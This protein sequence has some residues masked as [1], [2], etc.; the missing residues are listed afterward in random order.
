MPAGDHLAGRFSSVYRDYLSGAERTFFAPGAEKMVW[1]KVVQTTDPS[2]QRTWFSLFRSIAITETGLMNLGKTWES[3]LLPGGLKLNEDELCMPAL[4]LAMN[5]HSDTDEIIT[6][7]RERIT[8]NDHLMRFDFVVPSVSPD[9]AVRDA[10]FDS[11]RDPVNREHEP[12]VLEAPGYLH[13]PDGSS[14][15]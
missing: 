10:F 2:I 3:G 14:L 9:Q 6:R 11:L 4:T 15:G 1:Q 13:H 12:W 7:Q 8:S 5:G